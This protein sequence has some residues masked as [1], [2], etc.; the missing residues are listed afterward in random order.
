MLEFKT[1]GD[2]AFAELVLPR[3]D[4][5]VARELPHLPPRH[6]RAW[7]WSCAYWQTD[8]PL[9]AQKQGCDEHRLIPALVAYAE[10]VDASEADNWV[11]YRT[12]GGFEFR[13]G[14]RGDQSFSS[15]ELAHLPPAL[16]GDQQ[17]DALRQQFGAEVV[18]S[19]EV[20]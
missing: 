17:V 2:K 5:A 6:A 13:N 10:P 8:I 20:A 14:P 19:Q 12:D 1:S 9:S 18:E 16:I 11:L 7:R 4:A 3:P 15:Q